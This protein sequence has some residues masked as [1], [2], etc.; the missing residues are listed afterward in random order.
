MRPHHCQ[1]ETLEEAEPGEGPCEEGGG[2]EG[3]ARACRAVGLVV[4][5]PG[6]SFCVGGE[7]VGV[8]VSEPRRAAAAASWD[9][10][11]SMMW[12]LL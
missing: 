5:A 11:Q 1:K 3:G 4:S 2:G 7:V 8:V 12:V 10:F 6:F 9:Q